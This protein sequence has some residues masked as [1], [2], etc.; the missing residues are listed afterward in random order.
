MLAF[1]SNRAPRAAQTLVAT[2]PVLIADPF[3]QQY[4]I[5]GIKLAALK[6]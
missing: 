4:F 5:T 6:E 3:L 1:V 2:V